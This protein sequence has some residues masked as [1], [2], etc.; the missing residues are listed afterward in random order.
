MVKRNITTIII[1]AGGK[2]TRLEKLTTN[3]PKCLVS[4]NGLPMIMHLFKL[5]ADSKFIVIGDYKY[6][7]LDNY[8]KTFA[9]DYNYKLIR[10]DSD[11]TA[12]GIRDA[13][14][15]VPDDEPF[16]VT[17]CDLILSFDLNLPDNLSENNYIGISKEYECRWS[18]INNRCVK[19]PSKEN[20][21]AGFFIFKNK[22]QLRDCP[23]EGS[24]VGGY[25]SNNNFNFKRFE[26]LRSKEVGT[27]SVYNSQPQKIC[28]PFNDIVFYDN[29][30]EKTFLD[31]Q[32]KIIAKN[33]TDWY[34]KVKTLGYKHTPEI[35]KYEPLQMKRVNGKSLS[36]YDFDIDTKKNLL[37]N[38]VN[39]LKEL[40]NL[41]TIKA[42]RDDIIDTYINKT[43]SRLDKVKN[44]IPFAN[45]EF[46]SINNKECRNIFFIKKE[47]EESIKK[48]T[49]NDYTTTNDSNL[50]DH[51][52]VSD[53]N[54]I[55]KKDYTT[56][57]DFH[58]IHG[59]CT[60]SNI[61]YDED[62]KDILFID[63]RGYF[64]KTQFYGDID[65][66]WAKLYY[67]IIGNY[68]KFNTKNF[69]L[70]I[71]ED[72]VIFSIE[73]NGW[74][75]LEEYFFNLI[76]CSEERVRKI[77]LLH[78][79]IWLSLTTYS[80]DNYDSICGAFYCG[81]F[82][83]SSSLLPSLCEEGDKKEGDGREEERWIR[84]WEIM[85]IA[86]NWRKI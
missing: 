28:R 73:S 19:E 34:K 22:E 56:T 13:L 43:W 44:L 39:Y 84:G 77:R 15:Y 79:L 42:N 8:L 57:N 1:Q 41:E 17:W 62:K 49:V 36:C 66:D 69:N 23:A 30:I 52:T 85:V 9:T 31:Q 12:S 20:G 37:S 47:V 2:G 11:G 25:L 45:Q 50:I 10:A 83:L 86:N 58:L 40:H 60:F 75:E 76:G 6:D 48:Y 53:S 32:G 7:V 33:E 59:D 61:M 55:H 63:P 18:F 78:S 67:D 35:Y 3:K 54:L 21:I 27:M 29:Y 38:I 80:W 5:F 4:V 65:Y 68:S 26:L 14:T 72:K 71:Q 70:E 64:G 24:F 81:C 46:I 16:I 51:T 74:E 82:L